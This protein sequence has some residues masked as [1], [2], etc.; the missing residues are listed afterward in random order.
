MEDDRVSRR[1]LL[2]GVAAGAGVT[3]AGCSGGGEGTESSGQTPTETPTETE[4][5]SPTPTVAEEQLKDSMAVALPTDPTAGVWAVYGGVT[6]YYTNILEPL[7]WVSD[8]M[9]LVP[10]L[11]TDWEATSE[12]TWE[13]SIRE[14]VKFHNGDELTADDVVWSFKEIL[15]EWS[16][17]PG[18]WHVNPENVRKVDEYTMEMETNDPFPSLPGT[19]AH[20][21]ACVQH[22]DRDRDAN[23]VIGT[24]P[25]EVTT[26]EKGQRVEVERF[27]DYWDGPAEMANITFNVITDP[28][29]RTLALENHEIDVAY[30]P[31]S[32]KLDSLES[33]ESTK[34][35]KQTSPGA[36]YVGLHNYKAPTDD[37]KLR[38]ALNY[39]TSQETLVQTVLNNVGL[40]ARSPVA[41]SIY[42]S[43]HEK[44]PE[45]S[46]DMEKAKSLVEESSYNGET[47]KFLLSSE[48]PDGKTIATALQQ[49][50]N[51]IGVE[52]EIQQL[53]DAAF[54]DATRN[55]DG[56]M[57]LEVSGS[58]SGAADYLI[59]ES[60]HSEGDVNER[61]YKKNE[62][63][64][65]NPGGEVDTL[66]NEGFQASEKDVKEQKYEQALQIIV[67]EQ[68]SV[69]P[70]TYQ[71]YVVGARADVKNLD[72]RPI[73]EMVRWPTAKHL[74]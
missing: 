48:T 33:N 62:T 17:A 30:S 64:V 47:L 22:P 38:K 15:N 39:A 25:Y 34:T 23:E 44:L 41:K 3:F 18:W 36:M 4:T 59:Y 31:P 57:I 24:G 43:A 53:E 65:Y 6:P 49:W 10:W 51:Q 56:H 14:G 70:L 67:E 32:S 60:F 69:V 74:E 29:T 73:N 5:E 9:E 26:R 8:E 11:A 28:T 52:I 71:Q 55:G 46:Q 2:T 61:L 66:I 50:Y 58:N 13:F 54:E 12:T 42:W 27:D 37:V 35:Q 7:M 1:K 68:A 45:Y 20:N 16:W 21:M 40:P 72:L 63:G 19:I